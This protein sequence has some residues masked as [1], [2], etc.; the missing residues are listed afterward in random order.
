M[1]GTYHD[2]ITHYNVSTSIR[3]FLEV[4][5]CRKKHEIGLRDN[6]GMYYFRIDHPREPDIL[7]TLTQMKARINERV[8]IRDSEGLIDEK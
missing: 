4:H 6:K 1:W 7:H 8:F 2:K 5:E 3:R